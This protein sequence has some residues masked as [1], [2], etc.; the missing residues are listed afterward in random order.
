MNVRFRAVCDDAVPTVTLAP[1]WS[2]V[3]YLFPPGVSGGLQ[4]RTGKGASARQGGSGIGFFR[5]RKG[6]GLSG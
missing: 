3:S 4:P 2:L 5:P 1:R 6:P